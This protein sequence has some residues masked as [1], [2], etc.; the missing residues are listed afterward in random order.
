MHHDPAHG[1]DGPA[2][3]AAG[4]GS[5]HRDVLDGAGRDGRDGLDINHLRGILGVKAAQA[6]E[7]EAVQEN[8]TGCCLW[9]EERQGFIFLYH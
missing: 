3:A 6:A 5:V 4:V 8:Q 2:A 7:P 9:V 1:R